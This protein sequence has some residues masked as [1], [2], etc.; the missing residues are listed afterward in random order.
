MSNFYVCATNPEDA[1]ADALVRVLELERERFCAE[2]QEQEEMPT[3][4]AESINVAIAQSYA[5][6]AYI[7]ADAD[8]DIYPSADNLTFDIRISDLR[9]A[10]GSTDPLE[11]P[12]SYSMMLAALIGYADS[13]YACNIVVPAL[14]DELSKVQLFCPRKDIESSSDL[15]ELSY[16]NSADSDTFDVTRALYLMSADSCGPE[17]EVR[18]V[19]SYDIE[20]GKFRAL[21]R[22]GFVEVDEETLSYAKSDKWYKRD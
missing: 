6:N 13:A 19:A 20:D 22:N 11:L 5:L 4:L 15:I 3:F 18:I 12:P 1:P 21:D 14:A 10:D 16:D 9:R 2:Q 8:F 17:W 7:G